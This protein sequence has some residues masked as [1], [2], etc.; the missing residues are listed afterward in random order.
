MLFGEGRFAA[1][2]AVAKSIVA[3]GARSWTIC[4]IARPSSVGFGGEGSRRGR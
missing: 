3:P 2:N 4:A 1:L